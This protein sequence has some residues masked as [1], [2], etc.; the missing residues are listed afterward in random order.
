M[1]AAFKRYTSRLAATLA[2]CFP[3]TTA[4]LSDD[5]S[6]GVRHGRGV[7]RAPATAHAPVQPAAPA[8][9][10]APRATPPAPAAGAPRPAEPAAIYG[11]ARLRISGQQVRAM[12]ERV[13]RA[14]AAGLLAAPSSEQWP[15]I[16]ASEPL[17][18]IFAGAGSGKSSTLLLRVV[19]MLCHLGIPAE[20]LT[21]ISFTNASCAELR[22]QLARLLA[23]WD[24][25]DAARQ[26]G[27]CVRTFHAAM[28]RQARALLGSPGWFEQLD[29]RAAADDEP[30]NPLAGGRLGTAQQ[31]LLKDAYQRCYA[32]DA[33]FRAQVHALLELPPPASGKPGPAPLQGLRLAG[34]FAAVPLFEAFHAQAGFI[35]SLGLAIETLQPQTLDCPPRERLFVSA[36]QTFWRQFNADLEAEGLL[37]FNA[38][39]QRL[40]R[41]LDSDQAIAEPAVAPL[42]HLL[43][44]EFQDISP[45]IVHW[46]QALHGH[47][48]RRGLTPSLMAIGD[49]WQSIYGWRGSSPQ[50]FLDFDRH[51]P[52]HGQGRSRV[53][54][55]ETNYRSIEP[56][57]RAG[58]ALLAGVASKQAKTCRASRAV[59]EGDHGLRLVEGF[60]LASRLDELLGEIRA[61][62]AHAARRG[63]RERTAV[64]LLSRRNAPLQ[65]IQARLE[66]ELPVRALTIHRAK[67]LQAEVAII[68]DD[69]LPPPSHPLRNALYA[70]AGFTVSYDQAMHDESLRLGYVAITRGVSRVLWYTSGAARG[71]LAALRG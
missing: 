9:A 63:Q 70:C 60:D 32:E 44:D 61:Q 56:V 53:L 28:A 62:C 30:D 23:F 37:T 2:R 52:S 13:E 48:A 21:V 67:G 34:E 35:E 38:A 36:L 3:R 51:F 18:R 25:P 27:Q 71:A 54:R 12:R 64:L 5:N 49:D 45:Q 46:L 11:P 10:P 33:P 26:A 50:L 66:R 69:A 47:L 42:Q 15:M 16:L 31:R 14:V 39:F 65:Q 8:S 41:H 24:Y 1:L 22:A 29:S 58:E 40:T 17:T 7:L 55:L 68:L 43:I 19:F 59:Q 4:Y 6:P 57:I 20:R